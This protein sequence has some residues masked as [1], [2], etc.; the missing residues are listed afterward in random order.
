[1]AEKAVSKEA[2]N[3]WTENLFTIKS[4]IKNRFNIEEQTINKQ[5]GIPTDLDYVE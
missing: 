4:F 3:R 5:F 2:A 1:M